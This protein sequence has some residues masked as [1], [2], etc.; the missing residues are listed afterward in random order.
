M[1][2]PG[3]DLPRAV[4][5]RQPGAA[6][7]PA[8]LDRARDRAAARER[9]RPAEPTARSSLVFGGSLGARRINDA[10]LAA[11]AALGAT[12]PTSPST[13]SSA[14]ATGTTLGGRAPRAAGGGSQYQAVA[15]RG[16][17]CTLLLAAADL[18]VCRAGAS[19]VLELAAAGLPAVLVPS[20]DRHRATTRPANAA[21]LVRRR[22]PRSSC[23]T[24]SSTATGSAAERRRPRSPTRP[25]WPPWPRP[26]AAV[27]RPDAAD[28]VAAL[29][30]EHA[31]A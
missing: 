2:F 31:R 28:R 20:P 4:R 5:H 14:A 29:V 1:P 21:A 13:T 12:A 6:R 18:A 15:L 7:D 9:A 11:A 19:T 22:A 25:A 3:T 16:P 30:E 10:V 27:A 23:P 24:P 26:P 8:P 17:T